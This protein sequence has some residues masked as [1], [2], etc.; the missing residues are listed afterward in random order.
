MKKRRFLIAAPGG[1][2]MQP[3]LDVVTPFMSGT[4]SLPDALRDRERLLQEILD[5]YAARANNVRL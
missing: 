5:K 2:E 4:A 1:L 3:H